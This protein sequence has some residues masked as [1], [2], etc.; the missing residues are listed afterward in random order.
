MVMNIFFV[1]H[2]DKYSYN[3]VNYL[4][5]Y[6][7]KY[8]D[9]DYYCV[10]EKPNGVICNTIPCGPNL[11]TWWNKLW[12]F[13]L[14]LAGRNLYF[15]LDTKINGNPL[16]HLKWDGLT[17]VDCPWKNDIQINHNYDVK[18][19]SQV[20]TWTGDEQKHIWNHFITNADYFMRKY[21]GIDRFIVHEGF[22]YN[23][24]DQ[25]L[26]HSKKYGTYN[27]EPVTTFEELNETAIT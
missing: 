11:K 7:R 5:E 17:L 2:G 13:N 4:V 16:P 26:V 14:D 18:I 24:F 1:K 21:K 23:T 25:S 12:L 10:T 27:N 8:I 9:A 15:D 22:E 19:N 3:H 20:I 6:L